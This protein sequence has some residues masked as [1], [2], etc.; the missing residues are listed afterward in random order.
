MTAHP[1]PHVTLDDGLGNTRDL[2]GVPAPTPLG[3][4]RVT[5]HLANGRQISVELTEAGRGIRLYVPDGRIVFVPEVTNSA[6]VV[7]DTLS[8]DGVLG[9]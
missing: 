9:L 2:A 3:Y 1:A 5:F 4:E 6:L 7:I 8:G